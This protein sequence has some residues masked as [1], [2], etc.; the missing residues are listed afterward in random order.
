ME[1]FDKADICFV[2]LA[3]R[4]VN[5]QNLRRVVAE[6]YALNGGGIS[7]N[8]RLNAH[9]STKTGDTGMPPVRPVRIKNGLDFFINSALVVT[10]MALVGMVVYGFL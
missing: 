9:N 2:K 5:E 8:D 6:K 10:G 1:T 7:C 4:I 3:E